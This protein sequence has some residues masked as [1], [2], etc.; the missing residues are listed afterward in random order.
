MPQSSGH[1]S[2]CRSAVAFVLTFVFAVGNSFAGTIQ[3]DAFWK[4][5]SGN[6]IFSQGGGI[7]KA[8]ERYYWYG[9][10]YTAA[11]E[12]V[13][14]PASRKDRAIFQAVTCYS[15]T[16]LA[17]WKFEGR[18]LA[19]DQVGRGWFG[20]IGVVFN[21]ISG[22]YVLAGQGAAPNGPSGEYFATSDAP[23]GPFKF[24]R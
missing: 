12:Y 13:A 21:K 6:P 23:S 7:L 1:P 8:G 9:V 3:N 15:S 5:D 22:K 19:G 4:D 11:A 18:V 14:D 16:D 20:R 10:R 17:H 2:S 24:A